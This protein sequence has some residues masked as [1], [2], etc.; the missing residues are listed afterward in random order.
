MPSDAA[1]IR[2]PYVAGVFQWPIH[3]DTSAKTPDAST[4]APRGL[5]ADVEQ[6]LGYQT[7]F[8]APSRHDRSLY[9]GEQP[10]PEADPGRRRLAAESQLSNA[11][12]DMPPG[13]GTVPE[14]DGVARAIARRRHR[15]AFKYD[16]TLED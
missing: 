11:V 7:G 3:R 2:R 4:G 15:V 14:E 13:V 9:F 8:A 10:Q 12:L 6:S 16:R 5:Y 1:D